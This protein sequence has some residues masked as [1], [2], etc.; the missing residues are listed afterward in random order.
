MT[1]DECGLDVLVLE[2]EIDDVSIMFSF[3]SEEDM[4]VVRFVLPRVSGEIALEG[5]R[6][7]VG[8]PGVII[9]SKG[10]P[11]C[12][13]GRGDDAIFDGWDDWSFAESKRLG[14]PKG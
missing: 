13:G 7:L 2:G 9:V 14:N 1:V 10:E 5:F 8:A 4:M 6:A 11:E 12:K 3:D